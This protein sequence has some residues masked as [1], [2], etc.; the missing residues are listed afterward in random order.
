MF[1]ADLEEIKKS[2]YIMN[3]AINKI[4]NTLGGTNIRITEEEDRIREVEDSMVE[5]MNHKSPR[6]RRQKERP[7]ENT[8]G[9]NS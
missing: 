3:N 1:S 9:D 7:R 8:R 2:Q 5:I 6:R 4:K